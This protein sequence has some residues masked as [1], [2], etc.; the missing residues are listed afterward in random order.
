[1]PYG[2][3]SDVLSLPRWPYTRPVAVPLRVNCVT[4]LFLVSA[5]QTV[6]VTWLMVTSR[7]QLNPVRSDFSHPREPQSSWKLPLDVSNRSIRW[8]TVSAT[9]VWLSTA[10]PEGSF[11]PPGFG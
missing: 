9:N 7:G 4:R 11:N 10:R 1:M 6:P 3:C 8:L 2:Q 5:T